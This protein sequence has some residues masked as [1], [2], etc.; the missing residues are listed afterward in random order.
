MYCII[1][2]L[3]VI[4]TTLVTLCALANQQTLC[5]LANQ[6]PLF[7]IRYFR[8]TYG[9]AEW[10]SCKRLEICHDQVPMHHLDP[11]ALQTQNSRCMEKFIRPEKYAGDEILMNIASPFG[12]RDAS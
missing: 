2:V 9:L 4:G 8:Q 10:L 5:A 1:I 11:T 12:H 3:Y 6:K 7:Y